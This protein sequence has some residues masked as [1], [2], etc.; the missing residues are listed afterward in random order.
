MDAV[1]PK[2]EAIELPDVEMPF[3]QGKKISAHESARNVTEVIIAA[4]SG[5][6]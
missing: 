3:Q 4:S 6:Y 1:A 5:S 2:L